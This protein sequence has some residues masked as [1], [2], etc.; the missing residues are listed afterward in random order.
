MPPG[1]TTWS[2]LTQ[3]TGP[4]YTF[5]DETS[6]AMGFL[7]LDD[8]RFGINETIYKILLR[9]RPGGRQRYERRTRARLTCYSAGVKG[10]PTIAIVG[11][12]RLGTA[13]GLQ[14][15]QRGYSIDEIVAGPSVASQQKAR[16][17]ARRTGCLVSTLD[18]ARLQADVVWLCVPDRE[19]SRVAAHLGARQNWTGKVVFHS[20][21]ALP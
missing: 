7:A 16:A 9:T 18:K 10:Q 21:G 19:I 6:F 4:L 3:N 8:E 11:A 15:K 12:G 14:L 5:L 17:L 2:E 13:L 1:S 20:S